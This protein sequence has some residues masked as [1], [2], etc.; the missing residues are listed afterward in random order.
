MVFF[1][2][3]LFPADPNAVNPGAPETPEDNAIPESSPSSPDQTQ[4]GPVMPGNTGEWVGKGTLCQ[5]TE[6]K[7]SVE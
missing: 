2:I 1:F 3:L 5:E 4:I 7:K 6:K